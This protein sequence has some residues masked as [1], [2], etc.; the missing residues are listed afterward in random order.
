[1]EANP[2]MAGGET[3][4]LGMSQDLLSQFERTLSD[5]SPGQMQADLQTI[6]AASMS[7][8]ASVCTK[9]SLE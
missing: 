4:P 7:M 1:M 6:L 5:T 2:K 3:N 9:Q 8:A